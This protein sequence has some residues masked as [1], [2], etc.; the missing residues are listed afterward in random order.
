MATTASR[1]ARS[2]WIGHG[3]RE[4]GQIL[5]DAGQ[6]GGVCVA[7]LGR[8]LFRERLQS[9]RDLQLHAQIGRQAA[10]DRGQQVQRAVAECDV[11]PGSDVEHRFGAA[12]DSDGQAGHRPESL[13]RHGMVVAGG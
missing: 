4:V 8:G 5:V 11:V 1:R 10:G 9:P 3:T 6:E 13:R 7:G 12:G 2:D